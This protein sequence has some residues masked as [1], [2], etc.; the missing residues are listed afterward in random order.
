MSDSISPGA[1][2][3]IAF[4]ASAF[5]L[6]LTGGLYYKNYVPKV[7]TGGPSTSTFIQTFSLINWFKILYYFLPYALFLFGVIYDGL[8]RKIK[9]FPAGFVGLGAMALT[10]IITGATT[11]GTTDKDI[12]GVPGMSGWGSDIAPQNI[13]FASTVLS[14]LASYITASQT[15]SSYSGVAWAGVFSV[16][17]LQTI[18]Y[19]SNDCGSAK[20]WWFVGSSD[21]AKKIVPPFMGLLVGMLIGGS[22]GYGFS[23]LQGDDSGVGISSEAKQSLSKSGPAM[24]PTSATAGAGKCSPTGD[25]DQFV[26]EAYKNGE[27]VTSTIVE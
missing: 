12:C 22:S 18:L 14:Y 24:A 10:R 21:L 23:T 3:G 16:W 20:S 11:G 19:N 7:Y 13:V 6:L 4:G 17:V 5:T 26:C 9:F 8:V 27:L 25:D 15:D 2:V 1:A